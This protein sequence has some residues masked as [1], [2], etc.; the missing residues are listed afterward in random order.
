V[1]LTV[2]GI[3]Q[4]AIT[5]TGNIQAFGEPTVIDVVSNTGGGELILH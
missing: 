4:Y 3:Q 5:G 1:F 2:T